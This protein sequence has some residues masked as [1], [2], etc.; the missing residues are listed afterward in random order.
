MELVEPLPTDAVEDDK[1]GYS[2][3]DVPL[4]FTEPSSR[5]I[6]MP[7]RV[8]PETLP[9]VEP[10][11]P[12]KRPRGR[13]PGPNNEKFRHFPTPP[14]NKFQSSRPDKRHQPQSFFD[15]WG[16]LMADVE[17]A[18][19]CDVYAY[20]LFPVVDRQWDKHPD[21]RPKRNKAIEGPIG[22]AVE[23]LE[24]V[25]HRWGSGDYK[26]IMSDNGTEKQ[27]AVCW[28]DGIREYDAYPPVL[29]YVED[30]V[31]DDPKNGSYLTWR[32]QKGLPVPGE[33]S[34]QSI[35]DEKAR[36]DD[37]AAAEVVTQLANANQ[38]LTDKVFDMV[39]KG[40]NQPHAVSTPIPPAMDDKAFG[41]YAGAAT[42]AV[43]I[44]KDA[45]AESRGQ[46][47]RREDPVEQF[48]RMA[49]LMRELYPATG[50][51]ESEVVKSLMAQLAGMQGQLSA[52]QEARMADL[53]KRLEAQARESRVTPAAALAAAP[54]SAMEQ[55]R[56]IAALHKEFGSILG[57]EGKEE[58]E[59]GNGADG[60]WYTPFIPLLLPLGLYAMNMVGNMMHNYAVASTAASVPPG[61]LP[62]PAAPQPQAPPPPP[63]IPMGPDGKPDA[64]AA[65]TQMAQ[66]AQRSAMTP[67]QVKTQ[68]AQE[69]QHMNQARMLVG[70]IEK[71]LVTHINGGANGLEFAE[72]F[73][74]GYGRDTYS[75]IKAAGKQNLIDA[76]GAYSR[77][78]AA[79][80][81]GMP[82]GEADAFFDGFLSWTPPTPDESG[83]E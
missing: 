38:R 11:E 14:I 62:N 47:A 13:P 78:L 6:Q 36:V 79:L 81:S 80:F 75:I 59:S 30:L 1:T 52:M 19:R 33:K 27:I 82:P 7:I 3:T 20:R 5:A 66:Q 71:P 77:V 22:Q 35:I 10:V 61:T 23:K 67:E 73:V 51:G 50:G 28:I 21:G 74:A 46:Q 17:F 34:V 16:R 72:W 55:F 60:P 65:V 24:D 18:K 44:V 76:F 8:D 32:R 53:E 37:M 63:P 40:H 29:D 43:N 57:K 68:E 2:D 58:K 45:A 64:A 15:Y 48:S 39:E 9:E 31:K 26:L 12:G 69:S 25:W 4:V 54:K 83:E 41:L 70:M 42:A 56:E 49:T